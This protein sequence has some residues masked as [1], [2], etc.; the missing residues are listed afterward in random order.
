MRLVKIYIIVLCWF[1]K[2]SIAQ[3][4]FNNRYDNFNNGDLNTGINLLGQ[5]YLIYGCAANSFSFY[6]LNLGIVNSSGVRVKN[7]TY[8]WGSNLFV[9]CKNGEA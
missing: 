9:P 1:C 5:D 8:N 3:F 7:K 2:I 4:Y 6:S